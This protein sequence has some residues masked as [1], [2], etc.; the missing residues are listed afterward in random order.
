MTNEEMVKLA[1]MTDE[2]ALRIIMSLSGPDTPETLQEE[3]TE[4][5]GLVIQQA[6][7]HRKRKPVQ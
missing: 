5:N 6:L 3:D 2:E 1:A 7:F 4:L